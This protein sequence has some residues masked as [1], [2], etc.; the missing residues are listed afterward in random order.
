MVAVLLFGLLIAWPSHWRSSYCGSGLL[1][2]ELSGASHYRCNIN[3]RQ[4][5]LGERKNNRLIGKKPPNLIG[6]EE[7]NQGRKDLVVVQSFRINLQLWP[8]VHG[9]I[10]LHLQSTSWLVIYRIILFTIHFCDYTS[11]QALIK[12]TTT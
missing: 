2:L 10:T 7:E 6:T 5:C 4:D 11:H 3:K 1:K 9:V 12:R 8:V